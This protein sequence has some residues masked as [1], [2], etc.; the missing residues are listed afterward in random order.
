MK[1]SH[2]IL[3]RI[4]Y[5]SLI[6]LS[7]SQLSACSEQDKK[8]MAN[9]QSKGNIGELII[10]MDS[11]RWKGAIGDTLRNIFTTEVPGLLQSEPYF[12]LTYFHP[13]LF[14]NFIKTHRNLIFVTSLGDESSTGQR[15]RQFFSQSAIDKVN[16]DS[17][18]FM[19]PK[20]NEF[21]RNQH[22]LHLFGKTDKQL[23]ANLSRNKEAIRQ[24]FN[25]IELGRLNSNSFAPE[26]KELTA[27]IS[28]EHNFTMRI[29]EN[30]A[31]AKSDSNFVWVTRPAKDLNMH[32]FVAYKPYTSKEVF[33]PEKIIAWRDTIGYNEMYN[34][35]ITDS[36]MTYQDYIPPVFKNISFN[37][38][39]AVETR[40]LWR[41]KNNSRGGPFLSYT[42]VDETTN[43]LYYIEGFLLGPGIDKK[44]EFMRQLEAIL[45][46]FKPTGNPVTPAAPAS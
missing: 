36:Y 6:I 31:L 11:V 13:N 43:R 3:I 25:K 22:I 44:R 37:D 17:T 4:I 46:S 40:G 42:F 34:R 23:L 12:K 20:Q 21:A 8:D 26:N 29:P 32:V 45:W 1:Y 39:Y 24:Y 7:I 9:V 35:K 16:Q 10:I 14:N 38:R 33:E 18:F 2:P 28:K 19:L 27:Q 15:M 30:Y 41:L 5:F